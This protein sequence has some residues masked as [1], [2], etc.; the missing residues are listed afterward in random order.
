VSLD[1]AEI[2]RELDRNGVVELPNYLDEQTLAEC[3]R[4]VDDEK[5][6]RGAR[7]FSLVNVDREPGSPFGAATERLRLEALL[8]QV[9]ARG[10]SERLAA[11]SSIYNVLRVLMGATGLS[12]SHLYHYDASVVTA[13]MPLY[14]PD[15]TPEQSG[16][17]VMLPNLRPFRR[18]VLANFVAKAFWQNPL[19][20]RL[21]SDASVRDR[22]GAR[23]VQLKPGSLYLFWGYRT[24][25][26]NLPCDTN[27]LRATA[28]FHLG[29][30]HARS[31]IAS[32]VLAFR[33]LR[34]GLNSR[35]M[36]PAGN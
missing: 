9:C 12:R 16:E 14:I 32:S 22:L 36:R 29:D 4:F 28:I 26:G 1:V 23:L 34:E 7:Y 2:V 15:G 8:K 30:P 25:H 20:R 11:E 17:L 21:L 27:A 31:L 13:L 24:L 33:K 10:H 5:E 18:S 6:R 35:R 3:R 19:T